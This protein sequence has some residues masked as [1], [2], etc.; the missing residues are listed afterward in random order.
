M[1]INKWQLYKCR[2]LTLLLACIMTNCSHCNYEEK[3]ANNSATRHDDF[4]VDTLVICDTHFLATHYKNSLLYLTA[5]NRDT[6]FRTKDIF[7]KTRL[8]DFNFDGCQD[9]RAEIFSR[10][11]GECQLFLFDQAG[12][13]FRELSNVHPNAE[14]IANTNYYYSYER[15]G[16]GGGKWRSELFVVEGFKSIKVGRMNSDNCE[17]TGL[18]SIFRLDVNEN[19]I[20]YEE[21]TDAFTSEDGKR[22]FIQKYWKKTYSSFRL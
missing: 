16:C 17:N 20:L 12:K 4:V 19:E 3:E 2:Y 8:T 18:V 22:E 14:P 6:V 9:I 10:E 7:F 11:A 5:M 15:I 1:N 13:T 21:K